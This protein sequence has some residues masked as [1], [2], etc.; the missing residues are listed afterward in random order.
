MKNVLA[1]LLVLIFGVAHA[2]GQFIGD[3]FTAISEGAQGYPS[4]T[5]LGQVAENNIEDFFRYNK[6][7][8]MGVVAQ[9]ATVS[10][11]IEQEREM[12]FSYFLVL[13]IVVL[14]ELAIHMRTKSLFSIM[15]ASIAAVAGFVTL[16]SLV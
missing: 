13:C 2:E 5:A 1:L 15:A 12:K 16:F 4:A 9:N 8:V 3:G 14:V 11:V 10:T 6:D 7:D